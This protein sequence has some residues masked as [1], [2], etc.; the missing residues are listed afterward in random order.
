MKFLKSHEWIEVDGN[1]AKIGLSDYA[2]K[3]LGDIVYISL[4]EIDSDVS[5]GEEFGEVES[6]KAVSSVYSP[7]CGKVIAVNEELEGAPELVNQNPLGTWL[8]EVEYQGS[9]CE[10]LD[11]EAY[12]EYLKTL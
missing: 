1:V 8:I 12:K 4:P 7:C 11:E 10:L 6:V 9:K 3:E 5:C 2:A